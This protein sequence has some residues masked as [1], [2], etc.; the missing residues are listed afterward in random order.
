LREEEGVEA[1]VDDG[2]VWMESEG[3][4]PVRSR[5][6]AGGLR[7]GELLMLSDRPVG[8]MRAGGRKEGEASWP[9]MAGADNLFSPQ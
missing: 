2:S 6:A 7:E 3:R 9:A 5:L 4:P 1:E 8:V